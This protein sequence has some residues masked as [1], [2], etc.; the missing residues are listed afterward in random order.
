MK[1]DVFV[2]EM[3][4]RNEMNCKAEQ[5]PLKREADTYR[6]SLN[7]NGLNSR[8]PQSLRTP[9]NPSRDLDYEPFDQPSDDDYSKHFC[10]KK[11]HALEDSH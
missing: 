3:I 5:K 11:W 10:E 2:Q 7:L 1:N 6:T 9:S 8:A 4:S